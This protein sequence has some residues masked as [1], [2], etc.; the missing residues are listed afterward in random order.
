MN[1]GGGGRP[2]L[3]GPIILGG[4]GGGGPGGRGGGLVSFMSNR[5]GIF[6][7]GLGP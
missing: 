2:G 5:D 3:G 6:L 7:F 4:T 1:A